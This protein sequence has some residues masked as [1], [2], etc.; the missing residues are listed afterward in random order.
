MEEVYPPRNEKFVYISDYSFT[1]DRF[2][3]LESRICKFLEFRLQRVTPFHF[4]HIGL[5]ASQA[6]VAAACPH[7]LDHTVVKEL[8]LYLL[9][10]S[11]ASYGLS[12]RKPSLLAA[13]CMYLARATLGMRAPTDQAVEGNEFWTK[14]LQYYTGYRVQDLTGTAL[15]IHQWHMAAENSSTGVTPAF[16]KYRGETHLRVSLKT[17]PRVEDL[18]LETDMTH[19]TDLEVGENQEIVV[20]TMAL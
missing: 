2:N 9:E 4:V 8:T 16:S 5:R 1:S 17:V 11:R 10:L 14:T 7:F 15:R 18:G 6:C 19:N 12:L 20:Q 3:H 13:A